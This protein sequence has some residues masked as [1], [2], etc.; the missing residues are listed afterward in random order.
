MTDKVYAV[1]KGIN[2]A[3]EFKGLKAQYIGHVVGVVLGGMLLY[4]I[5]YACGLSSYICVP[6]ALGLGGF[7]IAKVLAMSKK[8]GQYGMMKWSAGRRVPKALVSRSR[9]VFIEIRKVHGNEVG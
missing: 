3:I 2:K 4:G 5:M 8:Y 1:N 7:G 6:V 9:K